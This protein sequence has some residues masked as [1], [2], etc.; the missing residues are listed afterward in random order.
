MTQVK[1]KHDARLKRHRRV[2]KKVTGTSARPRLAV[3]RS[4]R[5]MV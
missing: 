3:S 4:N 2:R 5:H 1:R